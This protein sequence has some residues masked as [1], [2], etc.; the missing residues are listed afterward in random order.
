MFPYLQKK[1]EPETFVRTV[2]ENLR[3]AFE[4]VRTLQKAAAAK[5]KARK[6]AQFKPDFKP[7]DML[8]LMTRE[9][10][11]GRLEGRDEEG[12]AIPLPE[13]LRN[14]FAG[15]YK[16]LRWVGERKCAIEISGMEHIHHV[17]RLIKHHVWDDIHE[18]TDIATPRPL[19]TPTAPPEKGDLILFPTTFN[20]ENKCFFGVGKV[21]EILGKNNI[22]FQ[23]YGYPPLP[24]AHKPFLPGWTDKID[25]K[26]YYATRKLHASHPAWTNDDTATEIGIESIIAQG[27]DILGENN[28]INKTHRER[29]ERAVGERIKWT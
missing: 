17:N 12:K 22:S 6:P 5:N 9:A 21:I 10:R 2:T 29:I 1:E 26:G 20:S 24:E 23:W 27:A 8:L 14:K 3:K 13:K 18:S 4:K 7:G 25:N 15:P 28:K 16:M 19:P 11:A